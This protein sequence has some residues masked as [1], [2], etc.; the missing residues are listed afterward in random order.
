MTD[1]VRTRF[2]PS[3]TGYLH[4]GGA[5]T[6]LFNYLLARH[7][8]GKFIVRIEDTDQTRNIAGAEQ[9][10]L[11]DLRWL[12]LQ[13]DEGPDVGGDAGPYHQSE[14]RQSYDEHARRLLESGQAYYALETAAELDAMRRAAQQR[15][16]RGFRYPRPKQFPSEAEAQRARDEGR[17]V[18]VRF[19]MPERDFVITDQIL[20]DVRVAATELSD[21]VIVKGDGWPTYHFAVVIDDAAMQITHVLRGQ[22][23]L[24]NSANHTALQ[25][26]FGYATPAYAHLPI[27]LN[28]DG[29]K[30]SKR[31]KDK[32]VRDAVSAALAS[33]TIEEGWIRELSGCDADEFAAWQKKKTQL[34]G[35][36]LGRLAQELTIAL[37]E[38]DIHDFRVSGYLPDV[39]VNFIA[40]LGWSAGDD[41][42]KYTL[43][44]LCQAFSVE[45]VGK[46]NARFDRDKLLSFNTDALA[47]AGA[48]RKLT[49][50]RDF[51]SV[52]PPG[53][54]SDLDD[55][56]LTRLLDMNPTLRTFRDVEQ[57]TAVLFAPDEDVR[58]D[59]ASVKKVLLRGDEAGLRVLREIAP[60]LEQLG[61]WS[62]A[63]LER[64]IRAFA[65]ARDLG[66]GKVAQP[67]RVAVTGT[68][69]SPAIFD[70][71]AVL[72]RARTVARIRQA[73]ARP[74][75][76]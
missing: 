2:A 23:H 36:A 33:K 37:P 13:W 59:P 63:A 52:N 42:E 72:G 75:S 57:K 18:V 68:T 34:E 73:L 3:P 46:T 32:V 14:R 9:K 31:E 58:Y 64:V 5:R 15:G 69:V 56:M 49:G 25:E 53:P 24:L 43:A 62:P 76:Q 55:A 11:A 39:I 45:R 8:G 16:E 51:L 17:P 21:F 70:T 44:G 28:T 48:D 6:A 74:E 54:L 22:E 66:L 29:S 41:R 7:A 47:A 10:L 26:A 30:M 61:D 19:K 71:L 40:L 12:G 60:E 38:I 20:G 4:I 27:I 67:L 65:E 1:I 50:L 35:P